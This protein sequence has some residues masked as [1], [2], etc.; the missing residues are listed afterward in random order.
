MSWVAPV[1]A[2][3]TAIA[4]TA[5]ARQASAAGKYNQSVQNRNAKVLEQDAQAIEQK[6]EFDIARFDKE[7]VKL[8]GETTTKLLFSGVELSGTGLEILANNA[9]E[10]E[11]EKDLIEY[12][13]N[14][15][16]SRKFE[17]ANFARIRGNIARNNAK[18]AE[19][20]YY[21]QAGTSLLTGFG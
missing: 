10:A 7:F 6:K 20:G 14:I 2:T 9:K 5:A 15:N 16:K 21:A 18:A 3:V 1:A 19:I 13:A 12:N 8:Q 11:I 4:A 17:E